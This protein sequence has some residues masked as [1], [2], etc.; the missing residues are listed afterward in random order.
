MPI[1]ALSMYFRPK[2]VQVPFTKSKFFSL[3]NLAPTVGFSLTTPKDDF[4]FGLSSELVRNVH[5][6]Y[7]YHYG[8]ITTLGPPGVD[9]PFLSTAPATVKRFK[10]NVFVGLTF[11]INF[12]PALFK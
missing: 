12:I 11:N 9:D 4:F 10:G 6:I 3:N 1:L 8:K 2:D 7:G 5:A